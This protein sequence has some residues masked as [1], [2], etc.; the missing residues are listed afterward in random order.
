MPKGAPLLCCNDRLPNLERSCCPHHCCFPDNDYRPSPESWGLP[1]V[2][3]PLGQDCD[4]EHFS[5]LKIVINLT[6]CGD[7]AGSKFSWGLGPVPSKGAVVRPIRPGEPRGVLGCVLGSSARASLRQ[8]RLGTLNSWVQAVRK[9]QL[10][11]AICWGSQHSNRGSIGKC[12][13]VSLFSYSSDC[14]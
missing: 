3:F 6:F 11:G 2:H 4:E 13:R 10:I 1:M 7:W 5:K 9:R 12:C 8:G 14:S